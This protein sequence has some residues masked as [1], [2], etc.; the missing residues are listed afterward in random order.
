MRWRVDG[1]M[2][3]PWKAGEAERPV[4]VYDGD[5]GFCRKWVERWR[6]ATGDA[7]E[8]LAQQDPACGR[9]FPKLTAEA[10]RESVHRV[11]PGGRV[12]SGAEAVL[13]TLG[14]ARRWRWFARVWLGGGWRLRF[15]EWVYR[16]V[17]R[18]RALL[19][20]LTRGW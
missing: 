5:C 16:R 2:S 8:Y 17:A 9:R 6:G 3:G 20:R 11:D 19:S 15:A 1:A 18:N 7:V 12:T 14:Q 10:L 4:L 13:L